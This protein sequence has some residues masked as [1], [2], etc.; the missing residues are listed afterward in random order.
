MDSSEQAVQALQ[1]NEWM[2]VLSLVGLLLLALAAIAFIIYYRRHEQEES[3]MRETLL[4]RLAQMEQRLRILEEQMRENHLA[5]NYILQQQQEKA[6]PPPEEKPIE[7]PPPVVVP[8]QQKI[9][10][11][12]AEILD[13]NKRGQNV[14]T[15]AREMELGQGEVQL[16]LSLNSKHHS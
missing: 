12:V 4:Y 8:L 3:S 10:P 5:I 1:S 2:V 16:I 11:Q 15:I 13:R 14:L 9:T 6:K 7:E